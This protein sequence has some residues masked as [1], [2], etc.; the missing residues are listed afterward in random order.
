MQC[1]VALTG[2]FK[3]SHRPQAVFSLAA[4]YAQSLHVAAAFE[5]LSV[6]CKE[7]R[8]LSSE[9]L[10]CSESTHAEMA[11]LFPHAATKTSAPSAGIRQAE[12]SE[13]AATF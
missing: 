6:Y 13:R 8:R 4:K 2:P 10:S 5:L 3:I 11:R 12:R 7:A 9:A 1:P